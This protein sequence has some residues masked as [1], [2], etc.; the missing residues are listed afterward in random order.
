MCSKQFGDGFYGVV[1]DGAGGVGVFNKE[2]A[3]FLA[4]RTPE[5]QRM[6]LDGTVEWMFSLSKD[7]HDG[8]IQKQAF[9]DAMLKTKVY[10]EGSFCTYSACWGN[11]G[12]RKL[13]FASVGDSVI[14]FFDRS[15]KNPELVW[16]TS[17]PEMRS[18]EEAPRLVNWL[19]EETYYIPIESFTLTERFTIVMAS[20][21]L[22]RWLFINLIQIDNTLWDRFTFQSSFRESLTM[23]SA[24]VQ[25]EAVAQHRGQVG[26][27]AFLDELKRIAKDEESFIAFLKEAISVGELVD[28]DFTL[29]IIDCELPKRS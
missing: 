6:L 1:C 19:F 26:L 23:S 29:M 25:M 16:M 15:R 8:V 9:D 21:A 14:F 4:T 7:F 18:I 12:E 13:Y 20:D 22:A 10:R 5:N 3:Q 27:S 2:W 11:Y 24:A 28:D 17:F